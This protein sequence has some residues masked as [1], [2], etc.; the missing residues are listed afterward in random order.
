MH[1][2]IGLQGSEVLKIYLKY[3]SY[4]VSFCDG[5]YYYPHADWDGFDDHLKDVPWE[6]IFK[7]SDSAATVEFCEWNHV[8]I[9]VY[10]PHHKYQAKPHSFSWF[11]TACVAT[12]VYRN[13]FYH[14]YQ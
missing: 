9:E 11:L 10:I 7:L 14:L 6:Y 1:S 3:A 8:G 2:S 13:H 5:A 4:T 12:R